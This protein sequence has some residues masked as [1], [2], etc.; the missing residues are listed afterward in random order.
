[1]NNNLK[2]T[3]VIIP[4]RGGSKRIVEKNIKII[5][6]YPMILWP[7]HTLNN[8]FNSE[9]ILVSTDSNKIKSVVESKGLKVPFRRPKSLSDDYT[10]VVEVTRHALKWYEENI[11]KVKFVLTVYPTA[12][13]LSEIDI[14]KA[15][16]MLEKN[17]KCDSIMSATNFTFPIQRAVYENN[18]GFAEMFYPNKYS[19]RSQDLVEAKH[20][21]G[22]FYLS[23]V[24]A[25]RNGKKLTNSKVKLYPLNR[26]TVIDIDTPEDFEIAEEKLK[27][28]KKKINPK[29]IITNDA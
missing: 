25:V 13:M 15:M 1:V 20:D 29:W 23:R 2:N 4:A 7:L 12:V 14:C 8:L 19:T 27:F 28:Y 16:E 22:Q 9:K 10:E 11:A 6:G 26:N 3:L 17:K 21:A 5:H 18:D 24:E